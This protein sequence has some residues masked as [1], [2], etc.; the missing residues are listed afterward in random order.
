MATLS[1]GLLALCLLTGAGECPLTTDPS[2][3]GGDGTGGPAV[4]IGGS[5]GA[6]W[7]LTYASQVRVT[8]RSKTQTASTTAQPGTDG[9][10]SLLGRTIDLT[11]LC[12]RTDVVCPDQVLTTHTS[13]VQ[14]SSDRFLVGFNR[15]GP[16]AA[17]TQQGLVGTLQGAALSVPMGMN[18]SKADPC[19]LVV[20]SVIN[21]TATV[22]SDSDPQAPRAEEMS[23]L[24]TLR[25]SG[26][27]VALGGSGA[28]YDDD[29]L[30]LALQFSGS[31]L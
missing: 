13:L 10:V 20:G 3:S 15:K 7:E 28:L 26:Q 29:Q 4:D 22:A 23:G 19:T 2:Q 18:A 24:V 11:T 1:L 17:L 21:A 16:L 30:E 27:C 31:R 12:W 5:S 6:V 8:L 14:S 9:A 25:Y